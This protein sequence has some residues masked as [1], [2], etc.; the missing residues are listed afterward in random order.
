MYTTDILD[1]CRRKA[2][3]RKKKHLCPIKYCLHLSLLGGTLRNPILH[4]AKPNISSAGQLGPWDYGG[5]ACQP[6]RQ[7]LNFAR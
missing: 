2:K 1:I 7:V 5:M 6:L 3:K 4:A